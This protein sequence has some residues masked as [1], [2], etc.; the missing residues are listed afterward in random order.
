MGYIQ[1]ALRE[2]ADAFI[3]LAGKCQAIFTAQCGMTV[4]IPQNSD[5]TSAANHQS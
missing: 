4:I 5:N 2:Q 3:N 1:G